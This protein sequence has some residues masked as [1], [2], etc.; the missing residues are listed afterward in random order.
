MRV[1]WTLNLLLFSLIFVVF[2]SALPVHATSMWDFQTV[3]A[4]VVRGGCSVALDSHNNPHITYSRY[5]SDDRGNATLKYAWRNGSA[6]DIQTVDPLMD[7][8]GGSSI[9][10][11][12]NGYPHISY[13][14]YDYTYWD[15]I[16]VELKYARWNG[17]GWSIQIVDKH[18]WGGSSMA[19]D[20]ANNPHICYS[21]KAGNLKYANLAGS[22]WSIQTLD[23]GKIRSGQSLVLDNNNNPHI[24]YSNNN[25]IYAYWNGSNWSFQ[26]VASGDADNSFQ[27]SFALDFNGY[28]NISYLRQTGGTLCYT[29]WNGTTWDIQ[30]PDPARIVGGGVGDGNSLALDSNNIP[31]LSYFAYDYNAG[32]ELK[33]AR[34]NGS[35]WIIQTLP[36]QEHLSFGFTFMVIDSN[37]NPQIG[38]FTNPSGGWRPVGNLNYGQLRIHTN[39]FPIT[40]DSRVFIIECYSHFGSNHCTVHIR[41]KKK[42]TKHKQLELAKLKKEICLFTGFL[43]SVL[44]RRCCCRLGRLARSC[45]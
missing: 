3:D 36:Y 11:D 39:T 15:S 38:Y 28:P 20:P 21:D 8:G 4:L 43:F 14:D 13:C 17:S 42:E 10:I 29:H 26:K 30:I 24:V 7:N 40:D 9:K 12:S 18:V 22:I 34:W 31:H 37:N 19:L 35:A 41:S 25:L 45:R 5:T 44:L 32:N 33:Y 27:Y 23:S 6:W 16:G 2:C 1:G